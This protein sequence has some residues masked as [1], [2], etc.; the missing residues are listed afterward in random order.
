MGAAVELP[1]RPARGSASSS[2]PGPA[3]EGATPGVCVVRR[4]GETREAVL[5]LVNFIQEELALH[6]L[7]S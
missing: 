4:R 3:F 6:D 5:K 2:A 1:G 7:R